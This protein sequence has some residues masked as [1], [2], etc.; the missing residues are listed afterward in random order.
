MCPWVL[1]HLFHSVCVCTTDNW[2]R[3][4]FRVTACMFL[5]ADVSK[6]ID[7]VLT[8]YLLLL[9]TLIKFTFVANFGFIHQIWSCLVYLNDICD[10]KWHL[11]CPTN[12]CPPPWILPKIFIFYT[13][14]TYTFVIPSSK[15]K[16]TTGSLTHTHAHTQQQQLQTKSNWACHIT[17]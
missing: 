17:C 16:H 15:Q 4:N 12:F 8:T 9:Q 10:P 1:S 7:H 6:T 5:R 11:K 2:S 14:L 13:V 3:S